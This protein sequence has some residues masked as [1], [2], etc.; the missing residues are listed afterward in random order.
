MDSKLLLEKITLLNNQTKTFVEEIKELARK[1]HP[2]NPVTPSLLGYFTFSI[3][4]TSNINEENII[5][6]DFQIKNLSPNTI[7][8]LYISIK[9]DATDRY[10]FSGKYK[11]NTYQTDRSISTYWNRF[12]QT[13]GEDED[14][15]LWFKLNNQKTL[16]PF[17]TISFSDFQLTWKSESFFSCSV[18]GFIYTDFA[19]NGITALNSINVS[20]N[21]KEI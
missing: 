10:N 2:S 13:D 5:L 8:D 21:G 14:N 11:T 1:Q 20:T 4:T 3:N 15:V 12:T 16:L 7:N 19:K 17:E 18:Q 6:G 9:I